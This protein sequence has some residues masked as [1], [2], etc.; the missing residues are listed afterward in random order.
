MLQKEGVLESAVV[1]APADREESHLYVAARTV[2]LQRYATA[3]ECPNPK[4]QQIEALGRFGFFETVLPPVW[5]SG[6]ER[7]LYCI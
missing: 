7:T 3:T 5:A 6:S 2:G 4:T 1:S